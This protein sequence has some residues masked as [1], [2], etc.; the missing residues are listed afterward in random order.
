MS[1]REAQTRL[2]ALKNNYTTP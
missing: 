1:K 2:I